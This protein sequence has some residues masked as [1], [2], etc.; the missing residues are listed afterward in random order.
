MLSRLPLVGP[1]KNAL[2]VVLEL[3]DERLDVLALALPV[4]DAL[5]GVGVEVLL[6]LVDQSLTLQRV[7]LL[8]LEL[9]DRNLVLGLRLMLLE[10]CKFKGTLPLL[11]L[12]LLL[13]HLQLFVA[14]LPELGELLLF[15][16][17]SSLDS[18]LALN[19]ELPAPLNGS[20]HL[21]LALLLLNEEPVGSV[22]SLSDL[23]VENLFLIVLQ[24]SE[25][26]DLSVDHALPSFLLF[27]ETFSF[28]LLLHVFEEFSLLCEGLD[29]FLLFDFLEAFGFFDFH[30]LLVC[31]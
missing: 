25:L 23:P 4:L 12:L 28:A 26:L 30:E 29:L 22:L 31:F 5:F 1:S 17:L 7:H 21:G 6:L 11:F 16:T 15:L 10:V 3:H 27:L 18:L 14:N 2:L 13:S 20:L 24:A 8:L 19:L 9:L